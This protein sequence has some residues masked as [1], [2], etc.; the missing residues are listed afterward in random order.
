MSGTN[1]GQ[2]KAPDIQGMSQDFIDLHGYWIS[3]HTDEST[4]PSRSDFD[5]SKVAPLLKNICLF[6]VHRDPF[7]FSL[8]LIGS[9]I[10]N[11]AADKRLHVSL[12][13]VYG[14]SWNSVKSELIDVLM[15]KKPVHRYG[16]P[17]LSGVSSDIVA[18][19]RLALPLSSNGHDVDIIL[20][21]VKFIWRDGITPP[22]DWARP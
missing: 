17:S 8:R 6:D 7:D 2:P 9:G 12:A 10:E 22:R 13:E 16:K 21:M 19:E 1:Y 3:I 20:G 4:I 5:P 18:D 11:S 15:K 14:P